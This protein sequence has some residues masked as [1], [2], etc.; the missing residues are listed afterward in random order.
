MPQ[1]LSAGMQGYSEQMVPVQTAS[2]QQ[3]T[4]GPV[5]LHRFASPEHAAIGDAASQNATLDIDLGGGDKLTYGQMVALAGDYFG[6]LDKI[7]DLAKTPDGQARL[8]WTRWW[9][10]N[11]GSE[12]PLDEAVKRQ[13]K[14]DYYSLA[15]KNM[16]HFAAGGTA[17]SHYEEMHKQALGAAFTSGATGDAVKWADA[18]A[19]EAFS[20]HYLT[21]MFSAGH[22]RTPRTEI[23]DWYQEHYPDSPARFVTHLARWMTNDLD[24]RKDIPSWLPNA[25]VES[26]IHDRVN[27]LGGTALESMSIGDLVSLSLHDRDNEGLNVISDVNAAGNPVS[28]GYHWRAVGDNHL[29]DA[30]KEAA[31][32]KTMAT[33]AVRASLSE[34][35]MAKESGLRATQGRCV[36]PAQLA[37]AMEKAITGLQPYLA[38]KFIPREDIMNR[39]EVGKGSDPA[40]SGEAIDWR[41][42]QMDEIA[43]AAVD[44]VIKTTVADTLRS[45]QGEVAAPTGIQHVQILLLSADLHVR[46]AFVAFCD[47]LA[48]SGI[49]VLEAALASPAQAPEPFPETV[50]A[51]VD[52]TQG[53]KNQAAGQ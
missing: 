18:M 16:S 46:A 29:G 44:H 49:L 38:E 51:G 22:V 26:G 17:K 25:R 2:P 7:R 11:L 24:R 10:L 36:P 9:A 53:A 20:N 31:E 50:D 37:Q 52:A 39:P 15:T 41:W 45:K 14:D 12:P 21:D 48:S 43:K 40:G 4:S 28:G 8:K 19:T 32:T 6:S 34:L 35:D 23:K 1:G 13:V 3:T 33:A 27:A 42:G 5:V 47:H 30:T